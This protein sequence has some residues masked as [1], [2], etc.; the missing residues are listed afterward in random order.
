MLQPGTRV[1]ESRQ[2]EMETGPAT[3]S[4]IPVCICLRTQQLF[5]DMS[6]VFPPPEKTAQSLGA[7]IAEVCTNIQGFHSWL[8]IVVAVLSTFLL[9]S[10]GKINVKVN[11]CC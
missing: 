11:R 7:P 2:G 8:W 3:P 4:P 1:E 9:S 10:C 6:G 5:Y